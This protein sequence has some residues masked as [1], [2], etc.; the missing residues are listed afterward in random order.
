M[1]NQG[2][3]MQLSKLQVDPGRLLE[4]GEFTQVSA[5]LLEMAPN[6]C[7]ESDR[8][9]LVVHQ[10]RA[11]VSQLKQEALVKNTVASRTQSALGVGWVGGGLELWRND[12]DDNNNNAG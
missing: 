8:Y 9:P 7:S 1:S 6:E 4:D 2:E 5:P 10:R 11:S 3:K 12:G